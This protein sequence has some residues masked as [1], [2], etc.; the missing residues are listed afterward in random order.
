MNNPDHIFLKLGNNL[1]GLKYLNSLMRTRDPRSW[2]KKIPIWDPGWK[3]VGS[4]IREKHA[5]SAT[6][7][8]RNG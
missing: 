2:M 3:K 7:V 6:L 4:R 8:S 1:F 5:G